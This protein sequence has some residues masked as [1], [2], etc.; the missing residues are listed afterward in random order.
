[1]AIQITTD[2]KILPMKDH[3]TLL[4]LHEAVGGYIEYVPITE[5]AKELT[6]HF[7]CTAMTKEN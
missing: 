3:P 1:M 4:E 7:I 2:G 5:W 6:G